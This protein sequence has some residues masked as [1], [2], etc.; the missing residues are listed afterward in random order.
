MI[1]VKKQYVSKHNSSTY[2]LRIYIFG[3]LVLKY[4]LTEEQL[5]PKILP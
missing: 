4:K 5:E 2:I 1:T 3:V